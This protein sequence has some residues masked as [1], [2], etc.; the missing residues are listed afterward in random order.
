MPHGDVV[1]PAKYVDAYVL[2]A[3]T[4]QMVII[5]AGARVAM[6]SATNN[7]YVNFAGAAAEPTVNITNGSGSELNPLARDIRGYSSFSVV[8]PSGCILTIAYFS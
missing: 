2:A 1:Y 5:P 6:F 7:F 3:A 8:S 4:P